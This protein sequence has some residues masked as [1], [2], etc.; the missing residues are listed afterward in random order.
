[1]LTVT[2]R[3]ATALETLLTQNDAEPGQGVKLIPKGTDDIA[4][5]IEAPSV[6]DEVIR[7]ADAP[8]LIVDSALTRPLDGAELDCDDAAID[9]QSAA[10]RFALRRPPDA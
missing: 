8:L 5:T 6:G 1:M 7:R 9:G 10:P 4:M 3:A 2:E